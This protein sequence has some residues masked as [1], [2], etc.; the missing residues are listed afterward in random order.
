M[1]L[2]LTK[3]SVGV[4]LRPQLDILWLVEELRPQ[5]KSMVDVVLRNAVICSPAWQLAARDV[6]A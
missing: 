1:P 2:K 4:E 6:R 3:V 5:R